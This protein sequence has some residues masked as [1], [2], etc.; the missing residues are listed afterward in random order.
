MNQNDLTERLQQLLDRLDEQQRLEFKQAVVRQA[1]FYVEI[2]LPP[3]D[4]DEGHRNG[5][6]SAR[7]WLQEPTAEKAHQAAAGA[8]GE[9]I[10]GGVRYFDYPEY[11]LLPAFVA[12]AAE[13]EQAAQF[14]RRAGVKAELYQ[15]HFKQ[16]VP[17]EAEEQVV[18]MA[19]SAALEWQIAVAQAILCAADLPPLN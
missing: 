18:A 17:D 10:D 1:I 7:R 16:I 8:A 14:A 11:F 5:I 9:C 6:I 2:L 3:A 13:V 19:Q 12:G 4:E 15:G